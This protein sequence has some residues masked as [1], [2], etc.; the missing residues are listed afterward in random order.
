VGIPFDILSLGRCSSY[1][2]SPAIDTVPEGEG[3]MIF[4]VDGAPRTFDGRNRRFRCTRGDYM[5]GTAEKI[6]SVTQN[7]DSPLDIMNTTAEQEF[8]SCDG[9]F[10]SG[11]ESTLVN[12]MLQPVEVYRG[13]F[14][15]ALIV[16]TTLGNQFCDGCLSTLEAGFWTRTG[17]RFLSVVPTTGGASVTGSLASSD[18]FLVME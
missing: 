10:G 5:N 17:S 2:I 7:F 3:V 13:K 6:L 4:A 9:L 8:P 14:H 11:D 12:P 1:P 15:C 16:K 18:S